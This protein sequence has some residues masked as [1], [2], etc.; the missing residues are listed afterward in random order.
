MCVMQIASQM[1]F[2]DAEQRLK[3]ILN[4]TVRKMTNCSIS[5]SFR[6]SK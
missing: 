1:H 2:D 5:M 4:H 3:E 6:E